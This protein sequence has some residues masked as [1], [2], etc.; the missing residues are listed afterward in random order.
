MRQ[1]NKEKGFT[2][3]EAMIAILVLTI[4]I[5]AVLQVFSLALSLEKSN[6]MRTQATFLSQE[7]TEEIS[8]QAYG[9]I[10]T[11]TEIEDPLSS[12]FEKFSRETK[13]SYLDANLQETTI[14]TGLKKIEVI[15]WWKSPLRIGEKNVKLVSLITKR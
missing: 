6:Q 4:G 3:L 10:V 7:K 13:I 2:F 9:D 14:D 5:V 1:D 15:V 12:P 11:G 8:S